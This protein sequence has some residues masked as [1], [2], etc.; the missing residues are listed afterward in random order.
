[1]KQKFSPKNVMR[2][3][4]IAALVATA[5][6]AIAADNSLQANKGAS[7]DLGTVDSVISAFTA[8]GMNGNARVAHSLNGTTISANI[9]HL[10][11]KD[12]VI[13]ISGTAVESPNSTFYLKG[14]KKSL[15]GYMVRHDTK[16][17]YEYSTNAAGRVI[18]TEVPITNVVPDLHP[19]WLKA[20]TIN[21]AVAAVHPTYSPMA[22]RQTVFIGPYNNEDVT[23]LQS[24]P[25]SSYVFFLD[26]REVMSGSTPLNGVTKENMYRM[27]QVVA[28]IYSPYNL[29]ITTDPAVY[30]AAKTANVAR[31]GI[32]H[33]YNQD[34][35]SSAPVSSFGTTSAGTLY[36]NPS[37]GFDYGY[38][39]GMT[40]AHEVGH[41][42]GML[43]DHGGTGGEYFEGLPAFQ[44]GPIMGNYWMGS[45]WANSMWTWSKGE[46]STASNFE[47]DL[48]IMNVDD[49]VPYIVDDN[50][51]GKALVVDAN[52]GVSSAA[53]WGQI[54]KTGDTDAFT[55]TTGASGGTLNLNIDRIEYFGMLDVSAKVLNSAGAVVA[56]SNPQA[57]RK[58]S[59]SNLSLPTGSYSVVIAGG[60]EGTPSNGFSNYSSLGYYAMSGTC[61]GCSGAVGNTETPL[62]KDVAV[63]GIAGATGANLL[64]SIAVPAGSSNLIFTLSGGTGNGNLYTQLNVAP[65]TTSYLAKSDG[66]SNA[67]TITIASPAAGTYKVLLNAASAVSGASLVATYGAAPATV[68]TKDVPVSIAGATGTQ[69][70]YSFNVPA[71]SQ[72]LSL[73]LSGGTGDGDIFIQ[74]GAEPTTTSYL[75]KSDGATNTESIL[76]AAPAAGTYKILMDASSAVS[77]ASLVASYQAIPVCSGTSL[78]SGQAVTGIAMAANATTLYSIVV[79][80]GKTSLTFKLSGGTGD[81][82]IF[83]KLGSA[84]TSTVYDKKSDGATNAETITFST[85]VAGTYYLLLKAYS[86]ISGVTLVAT[87][88]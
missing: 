70:K 22:Q 60:A 72:N 73:K 1:M 83:A 35:R 48:N 82:D 6:S 28:G 87:A 4:L 33:F 40:A 80:A 13:S 43:H 37:S 69:L 19:D 20:T 16:K 59:F 88:Q 14:N 26:N 3:L 52:G 51:S 79:P 10:Y 41:Q 15:R 5:C 18:L 68:L 11:N 64:Y 27:W 66:A 63:N 81:G 44:W 7:Q 76:I 9:S 23:K 50:P 84:P 25:G 47:N 55:F 38:G 12:G 56:S 85:P 61:N 36:R 30:N 21:T 86:A 57:D 65:T 45:G 53:N 49:A 77:G 8:Q 42:M 31:T 58:A 67:E 39:I 34:G 74:L 32:I 71:S 46:Y 78:C 24:R 2:P 75:A 54:E 29:N 62:T 17:A